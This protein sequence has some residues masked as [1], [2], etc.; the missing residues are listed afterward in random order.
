VPISQGECAG[1]IELLSAR[2]FDG[3]HSGEEV[4]AAVALKID[5]LIELLGATVEQTHENGKSPCG[6]HGLARNSRKSCGR[7]PSTSEQ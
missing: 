7:K 2:A 4:T 1:G 6:L 5:D 3:Q